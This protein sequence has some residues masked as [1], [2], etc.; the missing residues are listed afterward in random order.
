MSFDEAQRR[1]SY[2]NA[3]EILRRA[4]E[5]VGHPPASAPVLSSAEG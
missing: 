3:R 2:R 4:H 1:I 5:M